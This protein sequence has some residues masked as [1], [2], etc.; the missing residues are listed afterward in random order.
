MTELQ[1]N[2]IMVFNSINNTTC[3]TFE[4]CQKAKD[5]INEAKQIN[6]E[7]DKINHKYEVTNTICATDV[8]TCW[9]L[10]VKRTNLENQLKK[11]I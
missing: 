7:I 2:Y 9:N 1:K 8:V 4:E 11:F 6:Y 3:K 10:L 5:I